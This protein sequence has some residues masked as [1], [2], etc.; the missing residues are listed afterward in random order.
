M[1]LPRMTNSVD[2][3]QTA[4][5]GIVIR[6]LVMAKTEDPDQTVENCKQCRP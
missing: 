3:Y 6:L 2:P 4:K 1:R 5:N